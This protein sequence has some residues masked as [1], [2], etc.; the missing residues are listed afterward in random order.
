MKTAESASEIGDGDLGVDL[1]AVDGAVA[2]EFLDMA[3]GGASFEKMG[4][5]GVSE[6]MES[7]WSSA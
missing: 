1:G 7:Y 5:A 2:E 6:S 4:G 3:N